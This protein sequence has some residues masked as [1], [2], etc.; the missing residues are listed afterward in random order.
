MKIIHRVILIVML[1]CF[2]FVFFVVPASAAIAVGTGTYYTVYT[3]L[4]MHLPWQQLSVP[5]VGSTSTNYYRGIYYDSLGFETSSFYNSSTGD[6]ISKVGSTNTTSYLYPSSYGNVVKRLTQIGVEVDNESS[7]T[8]YAHYS[9]LLK[10]NLYY[11]SFATG[12][13]FSLKDFFWLPEYYYGVNNY[14][15]FGFAFSDDI[16]LDFH[17]ECVMR[18]I[19]GD[20]TTYQTFAYDVIDSNVFV[21]DTDV[22]ASFDGV[23]AYFNYDDEFDGCYFESIT[24]TV[25]D[26]P[27]TWNSL[28]HSDTSYAGDYLPSDGIWD[29]SLFDVQL[30]FDYWFTAYDADLY[31]GLVVEDDPRGPQDNDAYYR[32]YTSWVAMA[33]GGFFDFQVF[34]GFTLGGIVITCISFAVAIWLLKIFAGG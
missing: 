25:S 2:L 5:V 23:E 27:Y 34:P 32:D 7:P 28:S 15:S 21:F 16:T 14:N 4:S 33:V 19:G 9:Y 31:Y 6:R 11:C 12:L 8:I 17:L 1:L 18:P 10:N 13:E 26:N 30:E 29:S 22:I 3:P 24:L 20:Y